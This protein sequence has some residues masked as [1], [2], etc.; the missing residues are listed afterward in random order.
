MISHSLYQLL[1]GSTYYLRSG[2]RPCSS[3]LKK[4]KRYKN[5][6]KNT[7]S[8]CLTVKVLDCVSSNMTLSASESCYV[9]IIRYINCRICIYK[10]TDYLIFTLTDCNLRFPDIFRLLRP[11][12]PEVYMMKRRHYGLVDK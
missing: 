3:R 12:E 10:M 11:G 7:L 9:N 6:L 1:N 2:F 5:R 4:I 8:N